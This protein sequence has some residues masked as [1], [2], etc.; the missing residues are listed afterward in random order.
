MTFKTLEQARIAGGRDISDDE[1]AA[2]HRERVIVR[3]DAIA[4]FRLEDWGLQNLI[5]VKEK[6]T[7]YSYQPSSV[8]ADDG[9]AYIHDING[10]VYKKEGFSG[11]AVPGAQGE[12]G[13]QGP[14]ATPEMVHAVKALDAY[15]G[16]AFDFTKDAAAIIDPVTPANNTF[17]K[18]DEMAGVSFSRSTVG[19]EI[20]PSGT[21]VGSPVDTLRRAYDPLTG[22]LI[23]ARFARVSENLVS[24]SS[25]NSP[26]YVL[27]NCVAISQGASIVEGSTAW[28]Y[29]ANTN[30]A[31][32]HFANTPSASVVQGDEY[33]MWGIFEAGGLNELRLQFTT[34]AAAGTYVVF[35][36]TAETLTESG[37]IL[38]SG[39]TNLG[40][41]RYLIW[42][43]TLATANGSIKGLIRLMQN[44]SL[45]FA[46]NNV[47]GI[48]QHHFQINEGPAP[49]ALVPTSGSPI[50]HSSDYGFDLS[51]G[52]F[53]LSDTL[54]L[55]CDVT[56]L[57]A[58]D[59]A[60]RF[61]Q[62][63]NS[64]SDRFEFYLTATGA[65]GV[66]A[67][68]NGVTVSS[69]VSAPA[70]G[71]NRLCCVISP[72]ANGLHKFKYF[73]NGVLMGEF[74]NHLE[75]DELTL[76][77]VGSNYLTE[78]N[79]AEAIV[80]KVTVIDHALTDAEAIARTEL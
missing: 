59:T 68:F 38:Q 43:T 37:S 46:G 66:Q 63:G 24:H 80:H 51:L 53:T 9:D 25:Y 19:Y 54:S 1:F 30:L 10:R 34:N 12:Q 23:G 44:G 6:G 18:P 55:T 76:L 13:G 64:G 8:Q 22:K 69:S 20:G 57:P 33:C 45:S 67:R 61:F 29:A 70:E 47:D 62:I 77:K 5:F 50:T 39:F 73:M 28:K 2:Y 58:H 60:R 40:R 35:D 72:K 48:I 3:C 56:L 36:F 71:I 49:S 16:V 7:A 32:N 11:A 17:G 26:S 21:F 31:S 27:S 74:E 42:A 75:A 65:I 14:A 15:R 78:N 79:M 41:G 52:A 4:E